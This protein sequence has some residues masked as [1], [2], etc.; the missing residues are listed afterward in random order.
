M[1]H[2]GDIKNVNPAGVKMADSGLRGFA[3]FS[4]M[5][6]LLLTLLLE[7]LDQTVVSTALPRIISTLQGFD[8]YTWSVTAYALASITAI[9]IVG[10]LSDQFGRKGFLLAGTLIFLIGS[11][12]AGAAQNMDQFI[13]FRAIQGFGAGVGIGL[14]FSVIADIFT[15]KERL[16]WQSLFGVVYGFSNLVGP[17]IGGLLTD[18]GPVMGDIVTDSTRWRWVFYINLPVGLLALVGLALYLPTNRQTFHGQYRG[19]AAFRR[20]DFVGAILIAAATICLL[21][22][23]TW[24]SNKDFAWDSAQVIGILG[25]SAVLFILFIVVER[26]AAEPIIP[27]DLFRNRN[28]TMAAIISLVQFSALVGL[29]IYLPLYLQ[30]ILGESATSAGEV[31]TPFTISS[32]VGAMAGGILVTKVKKFKTITIIGA[33][34]MFVGVFLMSRMDAS[35][36]LWVA[37]IFMVIT[38][39]G[40]GP[41]FSILTLIAQNAV[42]RSKLGVGTGSARFFGQLGGVLGVA[43]VGTVVNNTLSSDLANRLPA[44]AHQLPPQ[45]LGLAT[46]PQALVNPTYHATVVQAVTGANPQ[47]QGLLDQI[48]QALKMAFETAIQQGF[49]AILIM[50]GIVVLGTFF[51]KDE[52]LVDEASLEAASEVQEERE[53][54]AAAV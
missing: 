12:L 29:I 3:F 21:L 38:G 50:S 49:L 27:L 48:F 1:S 31:I 53:V 51:F 13:A 35:T 23:L 46:N 33:I 20:I 30:G 25:A 8:R 34:T 37:M 5:G 14:V 9:P 11:V 41:F 10:K 16:K 39:L 40:V 22:G 2:E 47:A 19:W 7:A 43:V 28:F 45:V 6:S 36:S 42:P 44:A 54:T 18:H 15:L 24:G 32:V 26:F 52:S 17:T 4:V